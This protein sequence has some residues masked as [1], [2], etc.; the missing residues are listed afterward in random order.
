MHKFRVLVVVPPAHGTKKGEIHIEPLF[1]GETDDR[2]RSLA[3][4]IAVADVNPPG[5]FV[6]VHERTE[7]GAK[8][9]HRIEGKRRD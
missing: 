4:A 7:K 1:I 8:I 6:N 9:I 2:Y 3:A 5:V